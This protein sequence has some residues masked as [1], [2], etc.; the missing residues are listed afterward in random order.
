VAVKVPKAELA[1]DSEVASRL[2]RE[3][4]ILTSISHPHVVTVPRGLILHLARRRR[5]L[6]LEPSSPG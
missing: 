6:V 2:V 1:A 5:G 4:S 3:R